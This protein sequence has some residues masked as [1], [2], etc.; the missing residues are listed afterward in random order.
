MNFIES[1]WKLLKD[2]THMEPITTKRALIERLIQV[3]F[4]SEK[5]Q[6]L[7]KSLIQSMPKRVKALSDAKFC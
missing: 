5:N 4:H 3:Y 2:E 1:V 7:C 6:G